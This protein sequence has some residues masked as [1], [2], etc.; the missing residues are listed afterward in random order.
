MIDSNELIEINLDWHPNELFHHMHIHATVPALAKKPLF[1]F[2]RRQT[3][4][5]TLIPIIFLLI[6]C[7]KNNHIPNNQITSDQYKV[8]GNKIYSSSK[9]IQLIGANTF[10]VFAAGGSDLNS[11]HIDVAR[12][13]IGNVK[14]VP[15]SGFP[16]QDSTRSYLYSLQ[17]I[18]DSNRVN[19][20]I[21]II[22]P[23]RW[24][25][26]AT[27]D[28]SGKMPTQTYWWSDFKIKLQQ[29]ATQF[30]NQPDVW[31]EVWN[32]PYRYD[33]TDGYTDD[34]WMSNMNEMVDIIRNAGNTNVVLVPCAE[35]GQDESVLNSKG[36]SFLA[37]QMNILFD[38]HAY[39]KWLL[40]S[41]SEMST[42]L[43]QLKQNNIP[44]IFGETAPL[45]AGALMNPKALLDSAYNNG[46]S[47]C[48]WVWKYDDNDQ[49]ALLDTQGLPNDKNNN[50][51]G[52][53]FKA[54][55][56]QPRKPE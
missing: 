40:V 21:T 54:I 4:A 1:L 25:G 46:L 6:G 41:N 16:I 8:L 20:R 3:L 7:T 45:N 50:Y 29:W 55:S 33:R 9:A 32:E 38:I 22:C 12:E 51:W 56:L 49:D 19:N 42:R 43:R 39:E 14:E 5:K 18:V 34:V 48:A 35:Q 30:K 10:H 17:A 24:N 13:F 15:L 11:W 27:T 37:G 23:F 36:A 44:L 47:V 28:F 53:T 31:I 52:T 26:V 2:K